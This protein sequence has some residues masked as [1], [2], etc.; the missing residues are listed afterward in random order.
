MNSSSSNYQQDSADYS[1]IKKDW[2][3]QNFAIMDQDSLILKPH[4]GFP[5]SSSS[6]GYPSSLFQTLFDHTNLQSQDSVF[7]NHQSVAYSTSATNS[8]H[9]KL[10][11]FSTCLPKLA[12][13]P[14][15]TQA[16]QLSEILPSNYCTPYWNSSA[17]ATSDVR[18][19]ILI[20]PQNLTKKVIT[21]RRLLINSCL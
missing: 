3:A 1:Q 21:Y 2:S 12:S 9:K 5:L 18:A 20:N 16:L 8:C 11:E 19:S 14:K 10:N 15:P 6:Y 13:L 7:G 4:E 17:A